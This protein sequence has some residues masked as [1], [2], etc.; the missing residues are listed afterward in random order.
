MM[1]NGLIKGFINDESLPWE[2]AGEGVQRKILAYDD[3]LMLVKVRFK[4]GGVGALHRHPHSQI[5]FVDSGVFEIEL[6]GTKQIL[7]A[8]D[9]YYVAPEKLHGAVC[10]EDGML[11][12]AFSPNREDFLI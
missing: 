2:S 8:G 11:I 6:D 9:A 1:L 3:R 12:D 4:S 5:T 10:I 7:K